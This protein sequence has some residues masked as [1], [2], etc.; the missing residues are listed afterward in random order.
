MCEATIPPTLGANVFTNVNKST[1]PLSVPAESIDTYKEADQWKD[2]VNIKEP[3]F[4]LKYVVDGEEYK[5]YDVEYG[6][7]ITPEAE[8]IKEDYTFSGWS[9]IPGTMP[10]EDVTVIGTF[11]KID[12]TVIYGIIVKKLLANISC[13]SYND[14][15]NVAANG[16]SEDH[17]NA[18][19]IKRKPRPDRNA[20]E[21]KV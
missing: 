10:A 21:E 8:P 4:E 1:C 13:Q 2:F 6:S 12:Y 14:S 19:K 3:I 7:A 17:A 5:T 16:R 15:R 18:V 9:E 11:T 20:G